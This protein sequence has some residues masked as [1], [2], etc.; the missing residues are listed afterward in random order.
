MSEALIKSLLLVVNTVFSV[1][2]MIIMLRFL[3]QWV[4]ADF[5]NP[6]C[7]FLMKLTN[8]LLIPLRRIIPGFFGLD[9]AAIVLMIILQSL[10]LLANML[11]LGYPLSALIIVAA[12]IK[13]VQLLINVFFF[14]ILIRV[15]LS[16]V[17]PHNYHP[18]TTLVN[19]LTDPL[20]MPARRIIRPVSGFD[21]SP[22]VVMLTLQVVSYFVGALI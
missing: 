6:A 21:F 8:P 5:Y 2:I 14:A 22:L 18:M 12:I 13:L 19:Q 20:L 16:W 3:L 9:C 10:A 1:Y 15:V 11:I 4:K 7:Q 17:S